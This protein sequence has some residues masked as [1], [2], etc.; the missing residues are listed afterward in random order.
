MSDFFSIKF[1]Q[2]EWLWL[3]LIIP[4]VWFY[5]YYRASQKKALAVPTINA[6]PLEKSLFDTIIPILYYLRF[7]AF[8]LLIFSMARPQ[9]VKTS[10]SF[11]PKK[12]IDIILTVDLSLSMLA[13]DL[14]PDRLSALKRVAEQFVKDRPADRIGLVVYAG[15]AAVKIPLTTDKNFLINAIR[16]L[17]VNDQSRDRF[18]MADGTAIGVGLGTAVNHLKNSKAKSKVIILITDGKETVAFNNGLIHLDARNAAL[19]AKNKGLKVYTIGVGTDKK[20]IPAPFRLQNADLSLDGKLLQYIADQTG[21]AYFHA[22]SNDKLEEV[23]NQ[24]NQ[25]EKSDIS[26]KKFFEFKERYNIY[27]WIAFFVF[28]LEALCRMFIFRQLV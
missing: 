28:F 16:D 14:K 27:L 1:S 6:F 18:Q 26:V 2:P 4:L 3:L 10:S 5:D 19:I 21:G 24:I 11:D 23:Y 13:Q 25:L 8:A 12:G 9:N 7:F 17:K 15:E 22:T 20:Y